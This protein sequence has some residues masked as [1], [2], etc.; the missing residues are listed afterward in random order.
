MK[1]F[2]HFVVT[3]FGI[4]VSDHLWLLYRIELIENIVFQSLSHQRELSFRWLLLIDKNMP[5]IIKLR[6][7]KLSLLFSNMEIYELDSY[8]D[9]ISFTRDLSKTS[10]AQY[11]IQSRIDDDDALNIN[12]IGEI[13]SAIKK[14]LSAGNDV[15]AVGINGGYD[16]LCEDNTLTP[17]KA[18]NLALGLTIFNPSKHDIGIFDIKHDNLLNHYNNVG[19]STTI[20]LEGGGYLYTKHSLCDSSYFGMKSRVIKSRDKFI[21]LS[22][23][24]FWSKFG[25]TAENVNN[26]NKIFKEAPISYPSKALSFNS[27][28]DLC[29][30]D[31]DFY[32]DREKHV[33]MQKLLRYRINKT[34]VSILAC[35]DYSKKIA[36]SILDGKD[37]CG[38]LSTTHDIINENLNRTYDLIIIDEVVLNKM[39]SAHGLEKINTAL[40]KVRTSP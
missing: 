31:D 15:G 40:G 30:K 13:Q 23:S 34:K 5:E 10:N 38:T 26:L 11:V 22:S 18:D 8:K 7:K 21:E 12:A 25:L 2:E 4:G 27:K 17:N 36:E 32:S 24:N 33:R 19:V 3:P 16:Y 35:G 28:K 9:R 6:L 37:L 20:T 29:G 39:H 14:L 1:I